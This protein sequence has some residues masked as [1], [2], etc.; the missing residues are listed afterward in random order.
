M[1]KVQP[2]GFSNNTTLKKEVVPLIAESDEDC[3]F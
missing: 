1:Y 3:G 2:W